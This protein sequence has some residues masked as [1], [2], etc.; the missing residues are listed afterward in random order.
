MLKDNQVASSRQLS[1]ADFIEDDVFVQ[2][3]NKRVVDAAKNL[4]AKIAQREE[5]LLF[6]TLTTEQLRIL[7]RAIHSELEKRGVI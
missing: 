1:F 5:T 4:S 3:S 7:V 2:E 6:H